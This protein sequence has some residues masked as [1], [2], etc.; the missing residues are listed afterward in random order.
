MAPYRSPRSW[1]ISPL[2]TSNSGSPSAPSMRQPILSCFA[3]STAMALWSP[4]IIFTPTP[5]CSARAMVAAVSGRGGSRNVRM[6]SRSHRDASPGFVRATARDRTPRALSVSISA[7][8]AAL[9]AAGGSASARM[10]CG[11]PLLHLKVS[12][13]PLST[14]VASVRFVRGSKGTYSGWSKA[15]QRSR[16]AAPSTSVSSASFGGSRHLAARAAWT[17]TSRLP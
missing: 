11:A 3:M 8:T 1:G 5:S 14:S 9:T 15:S 6:P 12:W 17:R 7:S 16:S 10:T 2:S 13:E 4:V